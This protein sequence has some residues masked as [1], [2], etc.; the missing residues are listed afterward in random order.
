MKPDIV[1]LVWAVGITLILLLF[2]L[3]RF[4]RTGSGG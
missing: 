2:I 1:T 4:A 3:P